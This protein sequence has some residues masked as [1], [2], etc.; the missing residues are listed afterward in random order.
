MRATTV[1]AC[2]VT[3]EVTKAHSTVYRRI[4]KQKSANARSTVAR[5]QRD[6]D[7]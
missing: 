5:A 1:R 4:H 6:I 2:E 3:K 7:K